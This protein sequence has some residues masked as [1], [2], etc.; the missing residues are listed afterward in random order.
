MRK[1]LKKTKIIIEFD[2]ITDIVDC[3]ISSIL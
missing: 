3:I 2:A 1:A